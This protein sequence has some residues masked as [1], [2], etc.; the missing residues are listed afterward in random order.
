MLYFFGNWKMN[1]TKD[2]ITQFFTDLEAGLT[3]DENK[4]IIILPPFCYL[5][6]SRNALNGMT[7]AAKKNM[8]TF[9]SQFSNVGE[10]NVGD[11]RTGQVTAS[12]IKDCSAEYITVGL[13]ECREYLGVTN[14]ITNFQLKDAINNGM[15][16]VLCVGE[17][18]TEREAGQTQSVLEEQITTALNG[19]TVTQSTGVFV[20]Y[21]PLWAIGT[22]KICTADNFSDAANIIYNKLNALTFPNIPILYGGTVRN[23]TAESFIQA[24]PYCYGVLAAGASLTGAN[25]S[26]LVNAGNK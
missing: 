9:G 24:T 13:G 5:D 19:L 2:S 22:G 6:Y 17:K 7:T 26:A 16:A 3:A 14:A 25:F 1:Q 4:K 15:K 21:E 12:Q 20:A 23:T 10:V 8:I 11:F 18:I